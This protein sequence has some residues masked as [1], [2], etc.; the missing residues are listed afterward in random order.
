M[1]MSR[2]LFIVYIVAFVI[3]TGCASGK[4]SLKINKNGS[5][6]AE[7][8][9]QVNGQ[10]RLL[11]QSGM[12]E[13][14]ER[15]FEDAGFS[16]TSDSSDQGI[17]YIA[18]QHFDSVQEAQRTFKSQGGTGSSVSVDQVDGFLMNTYHLR[19]ELD[20]GRVMEEA[21]NGIEIPEFL[22]H[23]I[24]SQTDF[25]FEVTF[26]FNTVGENNADRKSESTLSW[27]I[28]LTEPTVIAADFQVPN[29][30][31]I[32]LIGIGACIAAALILVIWQRN[33]RRRKEE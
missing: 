10:A 11:L 12:E 8:M 2:K 6:D 20:L 4:G 25:Q 1:K 28:P 19:G 32:A 30:R 18:K 13:R 16:F 29:M 24:L 17:T 14:L 9:L 26:P 5:I 31:N 21:P 3:L 22:L 33:R 7:V 27:D 15:S 23:N